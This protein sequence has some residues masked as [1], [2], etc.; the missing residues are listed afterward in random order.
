MRDRGVGITALGL[1]LAIALRA[2]L[3]YIDIGGVTSALVGSLP[4]GV[5]VI[6]LASSLRTPGAKLALVGVLLNLA[7]M[8]AN[9]GAMPVFYGG[10]D[11]EDRTCPYSA[12]SPARHVTADEAQLSALADRFALP[13]AGRSVL[14]SVGDIFLGI[15]LLWVLSAAAMSSGSDR[16]ERGGIERQR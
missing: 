11:C 4:P 1:G 16:H 13:L 3:K 8:S 10:A 5:A 12:V 2:T 6:V 9:G 7:V 15:G 14:F